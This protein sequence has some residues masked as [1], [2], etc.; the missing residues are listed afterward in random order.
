[1]IKQMEPFRTWTRAFCALILLTTPGIAFAIGPPPDS[2]A[3]APDYDSRG[4]STNTLTQPPGGLLQSATDALTS[5][6]ATSDGDLR[7]SWSSLTGAPSRVSSATGALTD[8]SETEAREVARTFLFENLALFNLT[9]PDVSEIRISREYVTQHNGVTHLTIQQ[10]AAGIDV[11]AATIKINIDREG[12][13]LTVSSDL[14]PGIHDSL[15]A[16]TPVLTLDQ[17]AASAAEAASVENYRNVQS[18][19]LVY[20]PQGTTI[21]RL[22]WDVILEDVDSPNT[23]RT[24]IDAVDG[25]VLW[26]KS[27]TLYSHVDAHGDIYTNDSPKPNTEKGSSVGIVP[28]VDADFHGLEFF[29]HADPHADWW[30]GS[31]EADRSRTRSNNVRAHEDRAGDNSDGDGDVTSGANENYTFP[32][33]L[34]NDPSTYTDAAVVNLFYWNNRLHDMFYRLGFDEAAGNFQVDNFGLGGSDG[35]RVEADAQDNADGTPPSQCNANMSTDVDGMSPRMQMFE[36]GNQD[37]DLDNQV[38]VHEYTHGVHKRLLKTSGSQ[39]ANE[40]WADFFGLSLLAEP[41]D[42]RTGEYPIGQWLFNNSNG[43]RRQNYSVDQ[44]IFTRTYADISDGARCS[45]RVCSNDQTMTC[46]KNADCGDGN[47]CPALLCQFDPEC[48]PPNT[49]INQGTC[50]AQVHNTGELWSETLWLAFVDMVDKYGFGTGA[51]TMNRLVI[52]GMKF[53]PDDPT[54]LDGRN[55]ILDA[56]LATSGGINQCLIWSAFARMGMG[57]S[58]LTAGVSDIHPLE[59]FNTPPTCTPNIQVNAALD[60]GGVCVGSS[61]TRPLTVF[62]TATG[63]LVVRSVSRVSGSSAISVDSMP[64]VPVF[65]SPD[66]HVDFTIRCSPTSAGTKTATIRIETNDPDQPEV[67][68]I[69]TCSGGTPDID[70]VIAAA[71]DFGDVCLGDLRDLDLTISNS[72]SCELTVNNITSNSADFLAPGVMSLPFIVGSFDSVRVPIRFE[73]QGSAFGN[74]NGTITVASDDPDTPSKNVPVSGTVPSGDIRITGSADFGN[75]C[76]ESPEERTLSVCNVGACNLAV[77][78]ASLDNPDFTLVNSPF[79]ATVSPDSCLDV[80]VAFTPTSAGPKTCELT[81]DSDDPDTPNA[82]LGVSA[83]TPFASIDVPADQAFRPTVIQSVDSCQATRP[84]PVSNTGRCNLDITD[85]SISTNPVEYGLS[86]LPSFPIILAPGHVAGDGDLQAV[87]A[88]ETIDRDVEGAVSVTWVHD[89]ITGATASASRDLC[90]E[91]VRTGARVLVTRGGVPLE[92][93]KSIRLHRINANRNNKTHLDSLD[94]VRNISLQTVTPALPCTPFRYHREYGTVSNPVQLLP[95]SYQVSVQARI[96]G[97]I[98]K[99]TVGFD[100]NS[101]GF[102]PT[103]IVDF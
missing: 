76:A 103:I 65:I 61:A 33:N 75:V 7:I 97:K 10:Q 66:A 44:T 9:G 56:D 89:P 73:P 22:A 93:V 101:C 78:Q 60:F 21:S 43:L 42:D 28:R 16:Q 31:G 35:D 20:F 87:F 3:P 70:T 5:L 4:P 86:G 24:L 39:R 54:F 72:G 51:T 81:V 41:G 37:G 96:D 57:V 92:T 1:M 102:N 50:V 69:A 2:I 48:L 25:T 36:C 85:F 84:F 67:D 100:V 13:V 55:A 18:D 74:R 88:P 40:G 98:A 15:N 64:E 11:F 68:V 19:G 14:M 12:R 17:A 46:G 6:R 38:I 32:I 29:P 30:N 59:A 95:G 52:D 83:D 23:Y 90:G 71:G 45:V 26:R 8:A 53:S 58:A 27:L 94:N 63:D 47:T 49:T 34:N 80:V 82:T 62:N 79:P 91:G 77:S 99:R